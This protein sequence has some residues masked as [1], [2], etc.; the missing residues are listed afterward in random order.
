MAKQDLWASDRSDRL[1]GHSRDQN[2]PLGLQVVVC[3]EDG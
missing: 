1:C 3:G 2:C